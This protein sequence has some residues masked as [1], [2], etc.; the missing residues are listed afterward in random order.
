[1]LDNHTCQHPSARYVYRIYSNNVKHYGKQCLKCG[2]WKNMAKRKIP[3]S[4]LSNLPEY[5]SELRDKWQK[6][7]Q[8]ARELEWQEKQ[9]LWAKERQAKDDAWWKEYTAYLKTIDWH[10]RRHKA[11]ER[12][13]NLCQA[14][15]E[16]RATQVHHTTY[17][18][19][20]DAPI[21]ALVSICDDCHDKIHDRDW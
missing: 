10:D 6:D 16:M 14:C 21:F 18:H 5:N 15:L 9:A 7:A 19:G 1:M 4:K 2:E 11:L 17:K 13:N 12:D 8:A 3:R 20:F